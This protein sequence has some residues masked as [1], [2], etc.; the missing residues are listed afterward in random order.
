M[1]TVSA[2]EF[3]FADQGARFGSLAPT[4]SH[5][6]SSSIILN[7]VIF[8]RKYD[9]IKIDIANLKYLIL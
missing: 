1:K 4:N 9:Q 5:V 6:Y 8:K 3:K 7:Q 2:L